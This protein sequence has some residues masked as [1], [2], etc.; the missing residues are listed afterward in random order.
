MRTAIFQK[1]IVFVLFSFNVLIVQGQSIDGFKYKPNEE[2][3]LDN[4]ISNDVQF[5]GYTNY[6]HNTYDTWYRYGN[7]FKKSIPNLE[8]SILQSK[9]DIAEDI[10]LP[11][12]V[13]QE[14]FL[15]NLLSSSYT[16]LSNP[17]LTKLEEAISEGNV[18]IFIDPKS[19]IGKKTT[20]NINSENKRLDALKSHQYDDSSLIRANAFYLEKGDRKL[21]VVSSSDDST[22]KKLKDLINGTKEV[23]EKYALHKGWFAAE[24]L[25]KSVTCTQGHPLEVIGKGM[26]EGNSWFVFSGYMEYLTKKELEQWVDQADIPVVTDVGF[27]QIFGCKDYDGLQVQSMFTKESWIDFA[28]EKE[29]YIFRAVWD[30]LADPLHYDGYSA[31]EGNK[32]QIDEE[33]VPFILRTGNL[34]GAALSSMVLFIEKNQPLTNASMWNAIMDRREVGI[35]EGGR[36]MGPS[37]YRNG[38]FAFLCN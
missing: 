26:N 30:T 32:E 10:G 2:I 9:I 37:K 8:K 35:M 19:E 20:E 23:V 17:S 36:M 28:K 25:L 31:N 34:S 5:N 33:N 18:L 13:M 27:G 4:L 38:G 3:Q 14:G 22:K 15:S 24:T 16:E 29:G 6:W 11:G 1:I 21:F 7:L 12:F